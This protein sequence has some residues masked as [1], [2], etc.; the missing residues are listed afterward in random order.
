MKT[1]VAVVLIAVAMVFYMVLLGRQGLL[2]IQVGE[3]DAVVL[4][5]AVLLMPVVGAWVLFSTVR[6]GFQHQ[7]LARRIAEEGL[8]IDITDLPKRPSG[9]VERAA[10]DEL[11]AQVRAEAEA[12]PGNWR[13]YYR[14]AR[15]YDIAG[16]RKRARATMKQAIALEARERQGAAA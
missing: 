3:V 4:G 10:A 6:A 8:E 9:R 16:D 2:L 13:R 12:D 7:H 15:A 5:L 14:V 11:F 1:K